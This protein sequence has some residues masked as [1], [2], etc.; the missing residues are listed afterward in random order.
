MNLI[1]DIGNTAIK[2][3]FMSTKSDVLES[4]TFLLADSTKA[5]SYCQTNPYR[6]AILSS[7]GPNDI[8]VEFIK[9][10]KN[11]M[12]FDTNSKLPFRV[13]YETPNTLG[14]DRIANAAGAVSLF[15]GQNTLV[16]DAGTCLKFDFVDNQLNYLGGSISPGLSMRFK[17]L[18]T[19]TS[20]L[21]LI[22]NYT[23]D[24]PLIGTNTHSSMM[25]GCIKGMEN[26]I[27]KT[28]ENYQKQ[29]S[30]INILLTGGDAHFFENL[31]ISEKNTIFADPFLTLKGMN[32]ILN[33]NATTN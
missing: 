4:S 11:L 5:M 7:V 6:N 30:N 16:V 21:P 8:T 3:A 19:F 31:A 13:L 15:S 28:I 26:E 10:V 32:T 22:E 33:H 23:K 12:I 25:V 14:K 2:I 20:N 24:L 27:I 9:G 29:F 1:I 18:H 17:A